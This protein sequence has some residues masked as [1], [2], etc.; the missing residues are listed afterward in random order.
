M[1][2][3]RGSLGLYCVDLF[4]SEPLDDEQEAENEGPGKYICH[5]DFEGVATDN[6]REVQRIIESDHDFVCIRK[7]RNAEFFSSF[8]MGVQSYIDG[9]W[10]NAQGS[11]FTA[12]DIQPSDGPTKFL[13]E[14]LEQHKNLCP[15]QW[16]GVRDIDKLLDG[17]DKEMSDQEE[18]ENALDQ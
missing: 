11:L 1:N 7:R 12:R 8:G 6:L 17:P 9:D 10:I 14:Y 16:K 5:F 2:E 15:E 4:P 13:I 3:K 18:D